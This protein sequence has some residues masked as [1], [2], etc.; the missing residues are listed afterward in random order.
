MSWFEGQ[1]EIDHVSRGRCF[2]VRLKGENGT[3]LIMNTHIETRL[4][5]Q[6]KY[7]LMTRTARSI[8]CRNQ[9]LSFLAGD[10]NFVEEDDVRIPLDGSEA[11]VGSTTLARH[12]GFVF[13]SF[14]E[15][16]QPDYPQDPRA[17]RRHVRRSD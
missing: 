9:C 1:P 11:T 6:A 8:P 15:I 3:M 12:F 14:C 2:S 5:R 7:D 13:P 17:E 4:P 16:A 10:F